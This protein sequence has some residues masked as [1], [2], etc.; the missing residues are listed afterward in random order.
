[1]DITSE[2][3]TRVG[4]PPTPEQREQ[5]RCSFCRGTG[6][7]PF[8]ILSWLS[9]CCVCGGQGVVTVPAP[10]RRCAHC[11]GSG[12]VKT[13][14]CTV[15]RGTGFVPRLPGPTLCCPKC[16]GTGSDGAS[17]LACLQCRGWGVVPP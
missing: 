4:L 15:C 7:D 17:G 13:F 11:R 2:P 8:G 5:V 14:T 16:R 10:A 1:M 9:T 3:A 6:K 12:A